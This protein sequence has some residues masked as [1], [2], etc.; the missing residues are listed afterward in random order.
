MGV[1]PSFVLERFR[2]FSFDFLIPVC[3]PPGR[4]SVQIFPLAFFRTEILGSVVHL[5]QDLA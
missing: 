5:P 2:R 3:Q 4:V 1:F